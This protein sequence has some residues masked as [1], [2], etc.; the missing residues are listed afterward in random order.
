MYFR[1]T[2]PYNTAT[3]LPEG[4][5]SFEID[6]EREVV[7]SRAKEM[8][9]G[10]QEMVAGRKVDPEKAFANL[11][12]ALRLVNDR[13]GHLTGG[14]DLTK[15]HFRFFEG[16]IIGE[17]MGNGEIH[18]DPIMLMHPAVRMAYAIAHELFHQ[19]GKVK[20]ENV[21][22]AMAKIYFPDG[23]ME[24]VYEADKM[25]A[26]AATAGL[27]VEELY[28]MCF[29]EDFDGIFDRYLAGFSKTHEASDD[30]AEKALVQFRALFPE[31]SYVEEPGMWTRK[32]PQFGPE[33]MNGGYA[34]VAK[35]VADG[36]TVNT[37]NANGAHIKDNS[38]EPT[39]AQRL[40]A[41]LD[42]TKN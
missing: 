1:S 15:L 5:A 19:N 22:D 32:R 24:N 28:Q 17:S 39:V 42:S 12:E 23:S 41:M 16:N 6:N 34:E 38:Q 27:S 36:V 25:E 7:A 3:D 18:M 35:P 40:K 8:L 37:V 10:G 29:K 14:L 26:F 30:N 20:I 13:V 2:N 9:A 11:E 21:T 31:L 4:G 33:D